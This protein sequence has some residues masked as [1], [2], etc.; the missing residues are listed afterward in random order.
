MLTLFYLNKTAI[1]HITKYLYI[2]NLKHFINLSN[3]QNLNRS[4]FILCEDD[5][6]LNRVHSAI[7]EIQDLGLGRYN[8][9]LENL[10]FSSTD[11]TDLRTNN[12]IYSKAFKL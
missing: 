9:H 7:E 6:A 3:N 5:I 1:K 8:H 2:I 10:Y 11:N 12:K 4:P